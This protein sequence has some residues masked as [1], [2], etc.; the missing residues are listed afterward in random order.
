ML[1][2]ENVFLKRCQMLIELEL[3]AAVVGL[4]GGGENL[5]H[6]SRIR[7]G[8]RVIGRELEL[9]A[10]DDH[11]SVGKQ[12]DCFDANP[13]VTAVRLA[14][15]ALQRLPESVIEVAL[16]SVVLRRISRHGED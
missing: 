3:L 2:D 7:N 5:K 13:L 12:V 15:R 16:N 10:N 8:H 6:N 11:I 14:R 1:R 4:G 9:A